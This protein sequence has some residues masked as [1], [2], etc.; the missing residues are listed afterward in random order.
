MSWR[1]PYNPN[2]DPYISPNPQD[3]APHWP[4]PDEQ[5]AAITGRVGDLP[6]PGNDRWGNSQLL[7]P[8]QSYTFINVGMQPMVGAMGIQLSFSVDGVHYTSFVPPIGSN[9]VVI[10]VIR[11]VDVKSGAFNETI[12]LSP[13]ESMPFCTLIAKALTVSV[14]IPSST[15]LP[16]VYVH[17]VACPVQTLDCESI[18]TPPLTSWS[19]VDTVSVAANTVGA[20]LAL[21][22]SPDT[23]QIFI[24]NNSAVDLL[25][26]FGS[27]IPGLGP[28][29]FSNMLL[30]GGIHAIWES[31]PEAFVGAVHGIFAGGGSAAQFATFTRGI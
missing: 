28:P 24:Q 2:E 1:N 11:A 29:P 10:D 30:P 13:N 15:P 23:K 20:F 12:V 22:A 26:G 25:L 14:S 9:S 17:A 8:G 5:L 18:I 31:E 19:D 4:R 27:F 16:G 3:W 6:R 21:P 7:K